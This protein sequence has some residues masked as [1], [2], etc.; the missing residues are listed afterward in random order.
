MV[1]GRRAFGDFGL[2]VGGL[3]YYYPGSTATPLS[4]SNSKNLSATSSGTVNNGELYIAGS[5][6]FITLK[7]NYAVTDYFSLPDSKGTSYLDLSANYDL[8]DGWGIQGHVGHLY[9][10]KLQV[11]LHDR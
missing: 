4:N 6:K 5:W 1:A 7:Y 3:Y 9:A 2:D 11:C 10:T 8:G